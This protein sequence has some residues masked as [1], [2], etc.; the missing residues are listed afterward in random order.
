MFS[1]RLAQAEDL[2]TLAY[3]AG[4]TF[5]ETYTDAEERENNLAYVQAMLN[6][7]KWREALENPHQ[8]IFLLF[9]QARLVGFAHLDRETLPTALAGKQAL[10]LKRLYLLQTVHGKGAGKLLMKHCKAF[11]LQEGFDSLW[12]IVWEDNTKAVR[13]YE[14]QRFQRIGTHTFKVL[15]KEYDDWLMYCPLF[16]EN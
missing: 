10:Q 5:M 4:K 13:F 1:I 11:A 3:I 14:K 9:E 8:T 15:E 16:F 12:L 2:P 6:E 7:T